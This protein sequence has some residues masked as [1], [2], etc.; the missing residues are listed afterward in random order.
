MTQLLG[1]KREVDQLRAAVLQLQAGRVPMH[2]AAQGATIP[3][4]RD[5][6]VAGSGSTDERDLADFEIGTRNAEAGQDKQTGAVD[7][8]I[9]QGPAER[10]D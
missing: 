2:P 1:L 9:S 7:V 8:Q 6:A 5:G 4:G 10:V 3:A